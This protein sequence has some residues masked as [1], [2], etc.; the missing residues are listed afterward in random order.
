[1]CFQKKHDLAHKYFLNIDEDLPF[2]HNVLQM[3]LITTFH[4]KKLAINSMETRR[5]KNFKNFLL[6][7]I[8][9]L[10]VGVSLNSG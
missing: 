10:K 5:L 8:W 2:T 6:N 1:M 4:L 9:L 3:K 7:M